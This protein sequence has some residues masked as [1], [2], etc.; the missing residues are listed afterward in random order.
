MI[1][2]NVSVGE[3]VELLEV[4]DGRGNTIVGIELMPPNCTSKNGYCVLYYVCF[5]L[6]TKYFFLKRRGTEGTFLC[7]DFTKHN[8]CRNLP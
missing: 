5:I 4:D 2:E 3:D 1:I 6:T 7:S 8:P